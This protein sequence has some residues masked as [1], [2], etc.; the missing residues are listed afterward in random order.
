MV[1]IYSSFHRCVCVCVRMFTSQCFG[2]CGM[3][4]GHSLSTCDPGCLAEIIISRVFTFS[5]D[6]SVHGTMT[7]N[8]HRQP[9][10][11]WCRN[12]IQ[13]VSTVHQYR[14]PTQTGIN[15]VIRRGTSAQ[16]IITRSEYREFTQRVSAESQCR[17]SVQRIDTKTWV[18]RIN[19][20]S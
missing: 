9:I 19:T 20:E 12:T 18:L 3:R 14:S 10:Q 7:E 8:Q 17:Q 16:G 11:S 6:K 1:Q 13:I 4:V 15:A 5:R 2:V